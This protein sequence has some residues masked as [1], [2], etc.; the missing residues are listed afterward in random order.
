MRTGNQPR[1]EKGYKYLVET[2]KSFSNI[3]KREHRKKI[4]GREN[5]LIRENIG[6]TENRKYI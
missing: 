6:R 1:L 4:E 3:E 2:S 5:I